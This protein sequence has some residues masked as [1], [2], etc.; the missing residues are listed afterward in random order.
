MKNI[1]TSAKK[2][3]QGQN[4]KQDHELARV[5]ISGLHSAVVKCREDFEEQR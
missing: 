4:T 5:W 1:N 3:L 2:T